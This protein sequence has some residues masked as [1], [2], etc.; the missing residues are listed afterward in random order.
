M[1]LI[2]S[3]VAHRNGAWPQM[4]E[5]ISALATHASG[6]SDVSFGSHSRRFHDVGC[7]S[8]LPP[9]T[10]IVSETGHVRKVPLS[11][12]RTVCNCQLYSIIRSA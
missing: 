12:S 9:R 5:S 10:D 2:I 4:I 1:R 7:E 8:A 6:P 3:A 11:D